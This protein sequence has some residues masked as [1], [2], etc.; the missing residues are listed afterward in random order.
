MKTYFGTY[1]PGVA[2]HKVAVRD[3]ETGE[4]LPLRHHVRHSPAGFNWGY[5]GSGPAELAR[6]IL[7]DHLAPNGRR[8]DAC[9]DCG[10]SCR[11]HTGT[12]CH[13]CGELVINT[14]ERLVPPM[15]YQQFKADVVAKWPMDHG[16]T[17]T[18]DELD[19]WLEAKGAGHERLASR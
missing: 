19:E 8:L 6:C 11:G 9:P 12:Y 14:P 10:A 7:I 13:K 17:M 18:A 1:L 4:T 16:W 3:D 2:D 5:G 15:L